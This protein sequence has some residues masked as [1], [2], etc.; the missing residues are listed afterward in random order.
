[1]LFEMDRA[2]G[3]AVQNVKSANRCGNTMFNYMS[4][5]ITVTIR[6]SVPI[7]HFSIIKLTNLEIEL[8]C[9]HTD[10]ACVTV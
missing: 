2:A 4:P 7:S 6:T 5:N 3:T 9:R 1:M 10:S 8:L